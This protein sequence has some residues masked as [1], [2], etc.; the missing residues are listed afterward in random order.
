MKVAN[1]VLL[2]A[3]TGEDL[4]GVVK[5]G[6]RTWPATY[7][8]IA[9]KDYVAMGLAKWWTADATVPAIRAGRVTVAEFDDEIIGMTSVGPLDGHL[10]LWKL[11]VLPEYQ[12]GG[13]GG[14]LLRAAIAKA[15][16][17]GYDEL[18]LSYLDGNDSARGFYEHYGFV[19]IGRESSGSG[20]PDSVW[21]KLNLEDGTHG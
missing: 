8:P 5:V 3:A 11:Y 10:A 13:V 17:D 6:Q 21:L 1:G 15:K 2:R 9:G 18:R 7:A 12:S 4:Q 19:E 14:M 16:A 20:V